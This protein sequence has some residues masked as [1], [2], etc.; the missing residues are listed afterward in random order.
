MTNDAYHMSRPDLAEAKAAVEKLYG[1]RARDVWPG[2]LN[3]AGLSGHETDPAAIERLTEAMLGADP[4]LALCGRS[5]V[6]RLKSYEY[7]RAAAT[8]IA[9]AK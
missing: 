1:H 2:L 7:L 9:E 6:I 8:V 5:L 4:V 3:R